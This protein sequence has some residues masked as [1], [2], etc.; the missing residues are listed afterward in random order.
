MHPLLFSAGIISQAEDSLFTYEGETTFSNFFDP[1]FLPVFSP[2]FSSPELEAQAA[3]MCAGDQF[4]LFDVAAT[5]SMDIGLST[6]QGNLEFETIVNISLSGQ[7]VRGKGRSKA[8]RSYVALSIRNRFSL[9]LRG[10]RF[11]L[12][13][14]PHISYV[15][16]LS[17]DRF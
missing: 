4:C 17:K 14:A 16:L 11:S 15:H 10:A 12:A 8:E 2:S 5:G 3:A 1:N 9:Q 7:F 6:L 13:N